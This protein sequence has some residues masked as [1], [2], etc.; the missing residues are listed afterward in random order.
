M[1]VVCHNVSVS[2]AKYRFVLGTV[3]GLGPGRVCLLTKMVDYYNRISQA[4]YTG[5]MTGERGYPYRFYHRTTDAASIRGFRC[6]VDDTLFTDPR[7]TRTGFCGTYIAYLRPLQDR[8][9]QQLVQMGHVRRGAR[10]Y[11][12][13]LFV[14]AVAGRK[15]PTVYQ[16]RFYFSD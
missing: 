11:G 6:S 9:V 5:R 4:L 15:K 2:G 13:E 12:V 7:C 3:G 1:Q 8:L 14:D 16:C 10:L